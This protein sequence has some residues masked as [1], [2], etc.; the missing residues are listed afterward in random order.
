M[1]VNSILSE[2]RNCILFIFCFKTILA[3][4]VGHRAVAVIRRTSVGEEGVILKK[5]K[6]N[7]KPNF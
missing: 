3:E 4:V 6:K 2:K 1:S 7:L 5:K